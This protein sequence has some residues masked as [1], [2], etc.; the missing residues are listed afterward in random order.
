MTRGELEA[1]DEVA[2]MTSLRGGAD[3][4][5][6]PERVRIKAKACRSSQTPTSSLLVLTETLRVRV[7]CML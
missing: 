2:K 4:T 1:G 3:L 6:R 7:T 5:R